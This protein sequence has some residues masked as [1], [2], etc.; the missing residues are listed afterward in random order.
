ME[1]LQRSMVVRRLL[2]RQGT[3]VCGVGDMPAATVREAREQG[4]VIW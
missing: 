2:M 3:I 1:S 4:T